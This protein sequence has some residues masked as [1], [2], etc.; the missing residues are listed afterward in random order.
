MMLKKIIVLCLSL[1][2][3]VPIVDVHALLLGDAEL[4]L[5]DVGIVPIHPK[6]GEL[7]SITAD[8]YNAGLKNTNFFAS[9]I[10][11][12]YF[13]DGELLHVDEI[14]DVE[15]GIS[16]KIKI[17]SPP[18]WKSDMG[19]HEIKVIVD[20]H[21]TLGDQYDSPLDN[22]MAKILF[23]TPEKN[24][25]ISLEA[26]PQYFLLG[27]KLSQVTVSLFDSDTNELLN[28]KK[29]ILN[30]DGHYSSLVTNNQ[31]HV[32]FSNTLSSSSSNRIN[33]EASFSGDDVYPASNSSLILYQ[34]PKETSSALVLKL[35]DSDQYD[36]ENNFFEILIYQN[37]YEKLVKKIQLVPAALFD[38]ETFWVSLPHGH[39]YFAEIYLDGG[40][41]SVIDK[42]ELQADSVVVK[43]ISIPEMGKIKFMV[44]D[45][46]NPLVVG[47][48][49]TNW[50][51]MFSAEDGFTE[52][53][54]V[55]PATEDP[56]V[57]KIILSDGRIVKSEP[58]LVFPGEQKMVGIS[59]IPTSLN[60][61]IPSWIKNNAGWWAN[62][63]IDDSSFVE[64]IQFMVQEGIISIPLQSSDF[65][66]SVDEIPSWIKNNAGW[67]ANDLIDDSSFVEGIQFMVQ[68][69]L[70][71]LS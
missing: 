49:I 38:S 66:E 65:D 25:H 69:G 27:E 33:V 28:D 24:T 1:M 71:N 54:D 22:S 42:V 68:S 70:I 21:D 17:I 47:A 3:L 59:M 13:V 51:Y 6:N 53:I 62:D 30:F 5:D 9:M 4:I 20:Y 55:M 2:F 39:V 44:T 46:T 37:S 14:G 64:G 32:S 12:A 61:E 8:V 31:G 29:I 52:W 23:I 18:L 11:V 26:S 63:L 45:H 7:V 34:F 40:L 43:K 19:N 15:P 50:K 56:Y 60:N 16:N 48:M 35:S 41:F 67:W 58:F 57:A 36:F 10:T